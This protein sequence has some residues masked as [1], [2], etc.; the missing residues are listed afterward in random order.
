MTGNLLLDGLLT[1]C[2]WAALSLVVWLVL[3][4]AAAAFMSALFRGAEKLAA[5]TRRPAD[6]SEFDHDEETD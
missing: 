2:L 1:V 6:P 3:A 5:A 4:V